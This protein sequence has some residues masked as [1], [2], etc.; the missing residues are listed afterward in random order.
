MADP[1]TSC[2]E[3]DVLAYSPLILSTLEHLGVKLLLSVVDWVQRQ[4]PMLDLMKFLIK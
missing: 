2:V 4:P 3:A 1:V